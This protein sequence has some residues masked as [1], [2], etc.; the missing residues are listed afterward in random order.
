MASSGEDTTSAAA[1]ILVP[2]F[3][4]LV[5]FVLIGLA[6]PRVAAYLVTTSWQHFAQAVPEPG[7]S[8]ADMDALLASYREATKWQ[9]DNAELQKMH[10]RLALLALRPDRPDI[11]ALRNEAA[12]ALRAAIIAAPNDACAWATYAYA[13]TRY[14][15]PG[16]AAEP[17]LR[18]AYILSPPTPSC[19]TLRLSAMLARAP[20]LPEDLKPY[21]EADLRSLWASPQYRPDLVYVYRDAS[22]AAQTLMRET[23]ATQTRPT[24][25][26]FLKS[27]ANP[28]SKP[29][30]RPA[31]PVPA[32]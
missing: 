2:G 12:A 20:A 31:E 27:A 30:S 25:E 24:F 8:V 28:P 6:L 9:P 13:G 22:P 32:R 26:T 1:R 14:G 4:C 18:L 10:G 15:L 17:S 11:A 5:A 7:L 29:E 16:A 19:A 23:L 21:V 3:A